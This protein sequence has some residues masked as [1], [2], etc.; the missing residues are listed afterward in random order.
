MF[1]NSNALNLS[2]PLLSWVAHRAFL[3]NT[4]RSEWKEQSS[5]VVLG[6]STNERFAALGSGAF[7]QLRQCSRS[8]ISLPS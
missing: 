2:Y 7:L 5:G 3:W 8:F 4:N 1:H 6:G